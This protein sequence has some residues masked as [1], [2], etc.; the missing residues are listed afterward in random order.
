[1]N[2]LQQ[3]VQQV[4]DGLVESGT[5]DGLQAAVYRRGEL[6][7]DA[8]AGTAEPGA[9]RPVTPDTLFYIASAGK[10]ITATVVHVL[11][12]RGVLDY[13]TRLV[14]LWP[15]F[16]AHGKESGTVRHALNHTLGVPGV[17]ADTTV[18]SLRDWDRMCA[19][20]ADATPWWTPGERTGYHA[21]T[22]GFVLGEIV[23]RAT[24]KPISQVLAEEV[25]GPLGVADELFLAVPPAALPR[26][27][28]FVDDPGGAA[29]F[30]QLPPDFPLFKAGPRSLMP[31]A[32][33]AND[34][35]LMGRDVPAMGNATARALARMYAA[36]LD[37]VDGVRLVSPHRLT[38]LAAD[39]STGLDE[40]TG[41]PAHYGL[42][43]T[44]A[45]IGQAPAPATVFG[46]VGIGGSAC[47]AD[48]AT[49]ITVAVTK[50]HLNPVELN[51]YERVH[52]VVTRALA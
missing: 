39:T 5:E 52:E 51:A 4:L 26:R 35:D 15:E 1:M 9:D 23:R 42:G 49:G 31:S 48:T 45:S 16:G 22:F 11:V 28:R 32:A 29:M 17:P 40:L 30:A 18:D 10:G 13:D 6:V 19:T 36:L 20:I 44:V 37:E 41:A 46:M 50:N 27:A 34:T 8:V 24:G 25:A 21:I 38:E 33:W 43:Y 3:Q 14:E 47:Y 2:D 7:V 12:E